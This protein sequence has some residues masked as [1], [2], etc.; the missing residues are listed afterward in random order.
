MRFF[1]FNSGLKIVGE[2]VMSQDPYNDD[3]PIDN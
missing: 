1:G 3:R 2:F